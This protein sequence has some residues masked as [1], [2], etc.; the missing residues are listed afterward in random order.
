MLVGARLD[1]GAAVTVLVKGEQKSL[2]MGQHRREK[3]GGTLRHLGTQRELTVLWCQA[4]LQ[5]VAG[6]P[7]AA[8]SKSGVKKQVLNSP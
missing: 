7:C 2:R 3:L 5:R 8:R 4:S 6:L 1:C